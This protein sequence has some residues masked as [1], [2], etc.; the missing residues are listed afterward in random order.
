VEWDINCTVEAMELCEE[1]CGPEPDCPGPVND[2]CSDKLVIFDDVTT[3]STIGAT[4]D[5]G[6]TDCTGDCCL[7]GDP[8]IHNDVWY[9]YE[10]LC[11]GTLTVSTCDTVNYDSKIGIYDGCGACPYGGNEIGCNDDGPG[12]L[13]YSSL[14]TADVVEGNCYTIRIGGYGLLDSG[15]GTVL[16]DCAP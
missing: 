8:L 3:F 14:A 7:W 13:E 10:A 5:G 11:S 1:L 12:C 6:E 4:T 2:D 16:V 15:S 9:S